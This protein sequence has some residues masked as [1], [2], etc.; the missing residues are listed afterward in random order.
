MWMAQLPLVVGKLQRI[1]R[2]E[3]EPQLVGA[4]H[5]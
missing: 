5:Q 2:T 1:N 3:T 4:I